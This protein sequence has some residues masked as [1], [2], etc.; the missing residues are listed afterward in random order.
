MKT[1]YFIIL[2]LFFTSITLFAQQRIIGGSAIDITQ[3]PFQ[4]AIFIYG[5]YTGGGV[6]INNQWI[7]TVAHIAEK[8]SVSQMSISLGYTNLNNDT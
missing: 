3:R 4:V 6:I 1:K 2:A 5:K 7:L 8:Y